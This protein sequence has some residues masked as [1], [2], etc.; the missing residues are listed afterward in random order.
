MHACL[1]LG[2]PAF[3]C[4]LSSEKSHQAAQSSRRPMQGSAE[5]R[6]RQTTVLHVR[7]TSNSGSWRP[8]LRRSLPS[9]ASLSAL[10]EPVLFHNL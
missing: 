6:K 7:R 1:I 5:E 8:P 9:F 10:D 2:D 3:V 4:V